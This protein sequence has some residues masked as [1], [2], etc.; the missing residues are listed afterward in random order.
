MQSKGKDRCNAIY[1]V[2]CEESADDG[3]GGGGHGG[4]Y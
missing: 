1:I 4:D 3:G 2:A